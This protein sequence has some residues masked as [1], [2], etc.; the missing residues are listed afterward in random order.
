MKNSYFFQRLAL[1]RNKS[2]LKF[3][4][5]LMLFVAMSVSE[6]WGQLLQQD[7]S[8]SS[9]LSDYASASNPTNSQ[10]NAISSSGS[11]VVWSVT[12]GKLR[13]AWSGSNAGAATRTTDFS[14]NPTSLMIKFDLQ[15]SGNSTA[16][17]G[18]VYFSVGSG[19]STANSA[20]TG[21]NVHSRFAINTTATGG[22]FA[23]R[24]NESTATNSSNML[25][26]QSITWI[27]NNSGATLTYK[28]PD[29]TFEQVANDT[30]DIWAGTT[31]VFN[32]I[33]ALTATQSLKDFKFY[34]NTAATVNID[35]DNILIDPIPIIPTSSS[36]SNVTASGFQANWLTVSGVTGYRLDVSTASDFSTFVSGYN[37]KYISGQSTNNY[38]ITDLNPN[39]TYYYRVRG[40]SQ[41]TGG[42]FASGNSTTQNTTT[43]SGTS[44]NLVLGSLT[45]FG[46][47]CINSTYGPNSFTISGTNLTNADVTVGALSGYTYST[48]ADGSYTPSLSIPQSGGSFS[49]TIYVK[50]S[51]T[52]SQSYSGNISV[53]GGGASSVNCA[54]SGTG[55]YA[56]PTDHP[57]GLTATANSSS[58]ITVTWT[59]AS[60]AQVPAGYIVKAAADPSSP[61]APADG[62][63]EADATLAKNIAQG[64]HQAVFTGLSASTTYN[65]SIWPYTNS[66]SSINYKT[67]GTVVTGSATT[68]TPLGVPVAT[69]ATDISA[70]GFTANWGAA[71][72]ATGYDVNVYTKTGG[73]GSVSVTQGFDAG[74]TAQTDW[75]FT[76]IGGTYTSNDN[77]GASSPSLKFDN[78]ADA[79]LTPTLPSSAT[80]LSFWMKGQGVSDGSSLLIEGYNGFNWVLIHNIVN[81][82]NTGITYLYT[83][84]TTPALPS[85]LTQFRFTYTKETGNIAF[86]DVNYKYGSAA[87][88][89][90][91][92]DSPFT[93]ASSTNKVI[94]SLNP[95]TEYFYT[96]VAKNASGS[97]AASNEISVTTDNSIVVNSA[98]NASA[99]ADCATCNVTVAN[100][101]TFTID[102]AKTYNSITVESG[103]K[104]NTTAPLTVG[105]LILKAVKDE[106]SFSSIIDATITAT[107]AKLF[108]TI[109]DTKWYYMAFPCDVT[110][111]DITKSNGESIGV[112]GTD[113]FIKYY[114]G[115]QRGNNGTAQTN[116]KHIEAIPTLTANRGYIFGLKTG[117]VELSIP[118]NSSVLEAESTD[119]NIAVAANKGAAANT[120]HGWNLIGHPYMSKYNAQS[121]ASAPDY[122]IM[123]NSDGKTYSQ[124]SKGAG[125]LPADLKPFAAYFVQVGAAGNIGFGRNG[126]QNVPA[127]VAAEVSENIRLNLTTATGADYTYLIMDNDQTT[128]YQIGEDMVKWLGTG[129]DVPQVYT[130]I[131][132]VSY[133]FNALPMA[134]VV[135]LPIGL[136]T[137]N[138]GASTI[139]VN[140]LQAPSLSKLLLTDKTEN[141]TTD[142][143]VSDY[144]FN[145]TAGS[146]NTRFVISAQRVPTADQISLIDAPSVISSNGKVVI[147]E[148]SPKTNIR[149]YDATGRLVMSKVA[150]ERSIEIP[151]QVV[152][153]YAVHIDAGIKNWT[154]KIVN[155]K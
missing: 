116:W 66:G 123:P 56:E 44:P 11:K 32:D 88:N 155:N 34:T 108:K 115:E 28:A 70:T 150:T 41:Y 31:K 110:V 122:M 1:R 15:I 98:V 38:N 79:V 75:I 80:E 129:T 113:W 67:D 100:T 57:A 141:I 63:A 13:I 21:S 50:F 12:S 73:S 29:G 147:N 78:D 90:P 60:G 76:A 102:A 69:A 43:T 82:T 49:Q 136:Y 103:G 95:G 30:W 96:V 81:P 14:G 23:I 120:N 84:S 118:L 153:M 16:V 132:D 104:L 68:E 77:F 46:N 37:D 121:N 59:D 22:Q 53:G 131:G 145:A 9:T 71:A 55:V 86:D 89:I 58:Q 87:E 107:S 74:T 151:L 61:S 4:G 45:D 124:T 112:L 125:T 27:V 33:A 109:D 99:L 152:G 18:V 128:E 137:K 140:A 143:L 94:T 133:A 97:S 142:L 2:F 39:T 65:F 5:L 7:F 130:L 114:D 154:I 101:G 126:R 138:A 54:A 52:A 36:A 51:P 6:G 134:S 135:N 40:A 19:Y 127:S 148:L 25:G 144:S 10:F 85:N 139:S 83:S 105:N 8:S 111:A 3:F 119:K 149:I 24:R 117:T 91:V 72:S 106:S 20:E 64:T 62:T 17:T 93:V 146:N 35:L 48:I 92:T 26:S 42:E 47:Q